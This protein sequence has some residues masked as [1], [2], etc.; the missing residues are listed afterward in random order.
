ML[1]DH[2][3]CKRTR[4][5]LPESKNDVPHHGGPVVAAINRAGAS[6]ARN[7]GGDN[8]KAWRMDQILTDSDDRRGAGATKGREKKVRDSAEERPK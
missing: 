2:R 7:E 8:G 5:V 1:R 6:A 3:F 4:R